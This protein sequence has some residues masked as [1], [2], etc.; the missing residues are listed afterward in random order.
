VTVLA[1]ANTPPTI[2]SATV[3]KSAI[4][5]G[6]TVTLTAAFGDPDAGDLH[7]IEILWHDSQKDKLQLP[8]GQHTVQVTH[9][10]VDNMTQYNNIHFTVKDRQSPPT[11]NDNVEGFGIDTVN[12]PLQVNNVAP[13]FSQRLGGVVV[14]KVEGQTGHVVIDGG[15]T[16]PGSNDVNHVLVN[17]GDGMGSGEKGGLT[18]TVSNHTFHC[19][20]QYQ[21]WPQQTYPIGLKVTD[22]D[23]G[24]D[25]YSTTVHIP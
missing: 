5:E 17:W 7:T 9:K 14:K 15:F 13:A 24:Q 10:Y 20:H 25:T 21:L 1:T 8:A 12:V 16:E 4:N 18:C 6:D 23:G 19:S 3:N 2:T 22:D 11:G